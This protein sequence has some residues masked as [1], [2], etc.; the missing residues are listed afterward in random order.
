MSPITLIIRPYCSPQTGKRVQGQFETRLDGCLIC[1]SHQP[2]LDAARVLAADGVDPA[3][4]IAVRHEGIAYDALRWKSFP[5]SDVGAP[6]RF[7]RDPAPDTRRSAERIH[8][9]AAT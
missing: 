3:T 6:V 7:E 8:A 9:E 5:R 4:P 2:L 1:I